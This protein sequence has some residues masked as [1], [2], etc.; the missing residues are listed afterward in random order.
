VDTFNK[1]VMVRH[2]YLWKDISSL[3]NI[4][5]KKDLPSTW[6]D[7]KFLNIDDLEKDPKYFYLF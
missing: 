6:Y 5:Y 1:K 7:K 2:V 4:N 3:P